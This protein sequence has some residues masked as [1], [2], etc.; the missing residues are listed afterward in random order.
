MFYVF[1]WV[2]PRRL[3]FI[4]RRFGTLCLFH[5]HRR[6][7]VW[8]WNRLSVPKRRNIKFRRRGIT[9]K[10]AHNI[11]N[12]AKVWYQEYLE[13]YCNYLQPNLIYL[14]LSLSL[15][16][17]SATINNI[18]HFMQ[19]V[20]NNCFCSIRLCRPFWILH[21]ISEAVF[22]ARTRGVGQ[23]K[24]ITLYIWTGP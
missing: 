21:I 17:E 5:L 12:T 18:S 2:I 22:A 16:V 11:Q 1:F 4:C 15:T 24:A 7:G 14:G 3:N 19:H 9:Q 20:N 6:I 8:R 13:V 23:S 10:K